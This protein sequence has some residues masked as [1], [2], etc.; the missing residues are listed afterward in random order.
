MTSK[1][2]PTLTDPGKRLDFLDHVIRQV[3][4]VWMLLRDKHVSMWTKAILPLALIYLVSPIDLIPDVFLGLG[5][6]DDL[7]VILLGMSLFVRLCPPDVVAYYT[8]QLERGDDSSE[9]KAVDA[10]Y[11]VIDEK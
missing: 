10:T 6:L 3:K 11:R 1:K 9:D 2:S 4:L 8:N 7:G 5:Q